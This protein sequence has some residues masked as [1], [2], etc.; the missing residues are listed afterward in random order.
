MEFSIVF[1]YFFFAHPLDHKTQEF[2][3]KTRGPANGQIISEY[4]FPKYQQKIWLISAI[5]PK[6]WSNQKN[7]VTFFH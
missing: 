5:A 4:N 7:K 3:I 2:W 6:E 1:M